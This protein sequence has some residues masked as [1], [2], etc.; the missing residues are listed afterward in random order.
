MSK[1]LTTCM[2]RVFM[3]KYQP[4]LSKF[5]ELMKYCTPLEA[6]FIE[7]YA[8]RGHKVKDMAEAWEK[9][10]DWVSGKIKSGCAA[11]H[12]A[13]YC[14]QYMSAVD[15]YLKDICLEVCTESRGALFHYPMVERVVQ[16]PL[17][18]STESSLANEVRKWYQRMKEEV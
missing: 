10:K 17:V 9:S 6:R 7:A 13:L 4:D 15:R 16:A 1:A 12:N 14:A 8:L 5:E 11:M 3:P 2:G 18:Y